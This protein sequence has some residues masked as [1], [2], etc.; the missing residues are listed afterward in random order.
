MKRK[1]GKR[2]KTGK[3]EKKKPQAHYGQ[4]K[5]IFFMFHI[6]LLFFFIIHRIA[7]SYFFKITQRIRKQP[8]TKLHYKNKLF[9]NA[10]HFKNKLFVKI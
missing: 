6:I 10:A 1:K 9:V 5:N 7:L 2:T 3:K 8:R 4:K